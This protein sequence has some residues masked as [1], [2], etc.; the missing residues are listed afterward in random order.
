M[1]LDVRMSAKT[2]VVTVNGIPTDGTPED[3]L[4]LERGFMVVSRRQAR[5]A[6]GEVRCAL[7]DAASMNTDL[8]PDGRPVVP[9]P[10]REAIRSSTEWR[11]DAQEIDELAYL[12]GLSSHEIDDLFRLA[13]TL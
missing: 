3:Q 10:M 8:H 9:W 11:R 13:L 6:L 4:R 7:L 12:L 1:M 2:G 5:L